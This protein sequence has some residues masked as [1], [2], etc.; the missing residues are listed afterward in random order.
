MTTTGAPAGWYP[1][2]SGTGGQRHFDGTAWT[3]HVVPPPPSYG[4][5]TFGKPPWKGA[6]YGRPAF[7][8]GALAPPGRRL[9]ARA[10]DALVLLPIAIVLVS[11]TLAIA[12]PHFG[13]IFPTISNDPNATVPLPG[14][15]WIYV[16]VF[17][18]LLATGIIMIFYEAIFT[19][20][21]G[22]TLGKAWLHIR[23][24]RTDG[25]PLGWGS[26]FGRITIYYL[27]GFA[28]WIGL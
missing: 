6:A 28:S 17:G 22:R 10:L 7:G 12:A 20:R 4:Y 1:D 8:P 23:P 3:E 9:G 14:F 24:V 13:P 25:H 15:V 27:F 18:C 19:V 16:T 11:I 21:Y 5:P 2:P 26:A